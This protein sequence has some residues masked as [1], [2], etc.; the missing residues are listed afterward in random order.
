VIWVLTG[1]GTGWKFSQV[2]Q[3]LLAGDRPTTI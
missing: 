2:P 1:T 3:M